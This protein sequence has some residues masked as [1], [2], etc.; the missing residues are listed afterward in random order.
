MAS[1]DKLHGTIVGGAADDES[2][3]LS[4]ESALAE[5]SVGVFHHAIERETASGEDTKRGVE[6]AHE[7]GGRDTFAGNIAQ[8]KEQAAGGFEKIAVITTDHAR[9]LIVVADVPAD[10]RQVGF[11]QERALDACGEGKIT[12]QGALLGGR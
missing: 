5:N 9:G 12:L 7:H 8:H 4:G 3:E 10:W 1:A 6:V 11:R 2:C